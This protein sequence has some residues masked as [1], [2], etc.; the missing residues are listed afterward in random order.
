MSVKRFAPAAIGVAL[1]LG[2]GAMLYDIRHSPE[3]TQKQYTAFQADTDILQDD[4]RSLLD[5]RRK[6]N[7][8]TENTTRYD[9]LRGDVGR[10][11]RQSL[12]LNAAHLAPCDHLS[13]LDTR[14]DLT[15]LGRS[16]SETPERYKDGAKDTLPLTREDRITAFERQAQQAMG[17]RI[18][19]ADIL[20]VAEAEFEKTQT[21]IAALEAALKARAD[22]TT[23][24]DFAR[25]TADISTSADELRARVTP[26]LRRTEAAF[27][28]RFDTLPPPAK[29][30][31]STRTPPRNAAAS[32]GGT[33][34]GMVLYWDGKRYDHRL[35]MMLV[36]HEITPGHHLQIQSPTDELCGSARRKRGTAFTEGWAT[37]A[38]YLADED[39]FFD[40][41]AQ[42][43]GWLDYRLIRNMRAI[44]DGPRMI[45]GLSKDDAKVIWTVRMP[46]RLH[47]QFDRE[48][49]RLSAGRHYL[50]YVF[51]RRAIMDARIAL[52]AEDDFDE[53]LFH[54]ALLALR[55]YDMTALAA[56]VGVVMTILRATDNGTTASTMSN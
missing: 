34:N 9:A 15:R 51:G 38:E 19:Y 4:V 52:E 41:P 7:P 32:Y 17:Q 27:G 43:L 40:D 20:A 5:R 54:R 14:I 39:G 42:R 10:L 46:A 16:L 49:E 12:R 1:T 50:S 56:R 31:L 55:P 22:F 18:A 36:V 25:D 11:L 3:M 35:D 8:S 33:A 26:R 45:D 6:D 30:T 24:D 47:P 53:A 2:F 29:I 13:L 44:L 28:N 21:E 37:Y 23:L 48:W